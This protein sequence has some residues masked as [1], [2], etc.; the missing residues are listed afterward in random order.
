M[1]TV[2]CYKVVADAQDISIAPDRS[3]C[4]DK[5]AYMLG[6]YDLNAVE[7]AVRVAKETGGRAYLLSAGDAHVIDSK[8]KKAALSRGADELFAV[9]D[10]DMN[11]CDAYATAT[12]LAKALQNMEYDLVFFGEGSADLYAQQMGSLVG[13]LLGVTTVNAV[14]S[15]AVKD[16]AVMVERSL[17]NEVETLRVSLPAVLSVTSDI[18]LPR[19]PQLKDILAGGKKPTT[20]WS[21]DELDA[22]CTPCVETVSMLAPEVASRK[23]VVYEGDLGEAVKSLAAD[24]RAAR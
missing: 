3:L 17:E 24:I 15:V 10:E 2:A 23:Q 5:A 9:V 18:N 12:V 6:E 22:R 16:G 7:E 21:I 19:I 13:S 11:S 1:N 20:T 14:S 8:L 4:F